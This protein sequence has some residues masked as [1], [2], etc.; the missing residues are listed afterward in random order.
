MTQP[1]ITWH[2]SLSSPPHVFSVIEV[3]RVRM[4]TRLTPPKIVIDFYTL[5]DLSPV[6]RP[7]HNSAYRPLS[8]RNRIQAA[9]AVEAS[10]HNQASTMS[11]RPGS[12]QRPTHIPVPPPNL[13]G[14]PT[15]SPRPPSS[16]T[17]PRSS[18][19]PS[20]MRTRSR[21]V[22][23]PNAARGRTSPTPESPAPVGGSRDPSNGPPITQPGGGNVTRSVST[24][25]TG[26]MA[27]QVTTAN[28]TTN[29]D[30]PRPIPVAPKDMKNYRIRLV[31]HLETTR[32]LAF[33]PVVREMC[34]IIVS[35][36][37][38]P[39]AAA[40]SVTTTGPTVNGRAPALLLKIGRFT[41][42]SQ[43]PVPN[44]A[45]TGSGSG[46][47]GSGVDGPASLVFSGGGGEMT[48]SKVAFKSKV[49]SRSHA[50][51]WVEPGGKV[52]RRVVHME[53]R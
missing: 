10:R 22:T 7:R 33:E 6:P 42:K 13:T 50:E 12:S 38:T 17:S 28:G 18:F 8:T 4:T 40:A 32:S 19:L 25:V 9:A 21:T 52:S 5:D 16:P 47:L 31:P 37:I 48:S 3:K 41:D 20:F 15:G 29:D 39:S 51:I 30:A 23:Q 14:S 24:P 34:P 53:T 44:T 49:V 35:T 36:G 45:A 11:S 43:L 46:T 26:I 27:A 1:L 2:D